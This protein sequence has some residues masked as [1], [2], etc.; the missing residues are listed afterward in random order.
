[1]EVFFFLLSSLSVFNYD[2]WTERE[3]NRAREREKPGTSPGEP[4][5]SAFHKR[6]VL[7]IYT[8]HL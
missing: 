6:S 2:K 7:F 4:N 3:R 1:M 5:T 8:P